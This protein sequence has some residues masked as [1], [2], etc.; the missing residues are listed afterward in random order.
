MTVPNSTLVSKT[1]MPDIEIDL[2]E[3]KNSI[4]DDL[5]VSKVQS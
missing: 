3:M 1:E 5:T 4:I 2:L